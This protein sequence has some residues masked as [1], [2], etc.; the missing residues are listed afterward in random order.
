M[1]GCGH[2]DDAGAYV[3]GALSEQE[4]TDFVAHLRA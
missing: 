2:R 4:H 3:L 1:S